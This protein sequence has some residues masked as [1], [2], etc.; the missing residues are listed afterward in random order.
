MSSNNSERKYFIKG[1]PY[2]KIADREIGDGEKPFIIA[3]IGHNHMG[4]L[5]H[6]KKLFLLAK[7]AGAD[8]VKLQKRDNKNL[9]TVAM[10][11]QPYTGPNSFGMTYGEHREALEFNWGQWVELKR[12]AREIDI[13]L[14]ATAF[15]EDSAD[16]LFNLDLPAIKVASGDLKNIP[17]IRH[18]AF[19]GVPVIISTGGGTLSDIA[20]AAGVLQVLATNF[21]ILHCVASY[22][23]L[24]E[25]LNLLSI[26]RLSDIFPDIAIGFS[27]HYDGITAPISAYHYGA[28]IFEVHF[29]N[30]NNNK[31]NDHALSLEPK[32]LSE[33]VHCLN[34]VHK[35]RGDGIK[36]RLCREEQPLLKMEKSIYPVRPLPEGHRIDGGD[37]VIKSPGGGIP[38]Y[39]KGQVI[40]KITRCAFDENTPITWDKI[41]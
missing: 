6:C 39:Q 37:I 19:K 11:N 10:Y 18:I 5:D 9:Y 1:R 29:T 31:G 38:P 26:S 35:M 14:I 33:L 15:D 23:N 3:E 20:R 17:L 13:I 21:C 16:F 12:F 7:E 24:S 25:E 28:R 4:N 34:E 30:L 2:L 22:P 40:G 36:R 41:K 32:D 8:A 27:S